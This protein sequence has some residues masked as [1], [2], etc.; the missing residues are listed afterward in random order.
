[1]SGLITFSAVGRTEAPC[2]HASLGRFS[3]DRLAGTFGL[4]PLSVRA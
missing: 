4:R 2:G 1:M 3:P